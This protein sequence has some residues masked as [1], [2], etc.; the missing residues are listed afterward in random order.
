MGPDVAGDSL[1]VEITD[2]DLEESCQ[3][4]VR[5]DVHGQVLVDE[6]TYT[7]GASVIA[8]SKEQ[9]FSFLIPATAP[10]TN[11][12]NRVPNLPKLLEVLRK[13]NLK[14]SDIMEII[15]QIEHNDNVPS[16]TRIDLTSAVQNIP[17]KKQ[18][19]RERI[20]QASREL[21]QNFITPEQGNANQFNQFAQLHGLPS[22]VSGVAPT[23][24]QPPITGTVPLFNHLFTHLP[25]PLPDPNASNRPQREIHPVREEKASFTYSVATS[26]PGL[27]STQAH[28]ST[29]PNVVCFEL[30]I[31]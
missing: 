16:P 2:E 24:F 19:N 5:I 31:V 10:V 18:Q 28:F 27:Q 20:V 23:T 3:P 8:C 11:L 21:Q 15:S 25:R 6:D 7:A 30:L 1:G 12:P 22:H 9:F 29:P 13:S 26:A 14:E 4:F 17:L